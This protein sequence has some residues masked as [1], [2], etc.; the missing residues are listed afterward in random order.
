MYRACTAW[1]FQVQQPAGKPWA[2]SSFM[3]HSKKPTG[4]NKNKKGKTP[5]EQNWWN[6]FSTLWVKLRRSIKDFFNNSK[7]ELGE[8]KIAC[9]MEESSR[10]DWRRRR[11]SGRWKI[12]YTPQLNN[13]RLP[14][15]KNMR[16]HDAIEFVENSRRSERLNNIGGNG[17][18]NTEFAKHQGQ[19]KQKRSDGGGVAP[20]FPKPTFK[21]R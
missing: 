1:K 5:G 16:G 10:G 19:N 21:R 12:F 11:C 20:E 13:S 7:R 9:C 8:S 17:A 2:A 18:C 15:R 14:K 3:I 6:C 4:H